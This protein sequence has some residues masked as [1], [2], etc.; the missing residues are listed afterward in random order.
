[1]AKEGKRG[2]GKLALN[3][4]SETEIMLHAFNF[5]TLSR[6][7]VITLPHPRRS[8]LFSFLYSLFSYPI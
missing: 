5:S 4:N 6:F 2:K 7:H 3:W 1:M 8:H